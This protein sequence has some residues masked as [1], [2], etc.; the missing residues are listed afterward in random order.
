MRSYFCEKLASGVSLIFLPKVLIWNKIELLASNLL[1][2]SELVVNKRNPLQPGVAFL[3]PLKTLGFLMFSE[4][5][6]KQ[7]RAAM[8]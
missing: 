8:G 5:I 4:G 6:E 7:H 2:F 1:N 3:Y